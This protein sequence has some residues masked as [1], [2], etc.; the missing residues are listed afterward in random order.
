VNGGTADLDSIRA[1]LLHIGG[2]PFLFGLPAPA[3]VH[4]PNLKTPTAYGATP[5]RPRE[6]RLC[7]NLIT[8]ALFGA[9]GIHKSTQQL[10]GLSNMTSNQR[11]VL[12]QLAEEYFADWRAGLGTNPDDSFR[13]FLVWL[14]DQLDNLIV[15]CR[16]DPT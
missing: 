12:L 5:A 6:G 15:P 2:P 4:I 10:K 16:K 7:G 11:A 13:R 9:A 1:A 14:D 8:G 3:V